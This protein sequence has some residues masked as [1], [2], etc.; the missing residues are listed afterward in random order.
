[1]SAEQHAPLLGESA[2]LSFR[3]LCLPLLDVGDSV[4][5]S[6]LEDGAGLVPNVCI[7]LRAA[8]ASCISLDA[9]AAAAVSG[10]GLRANCE[11]EKGSLQ[12]CF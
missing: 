3:R 1:M 9:I 10:G 11:T 6:P 8:C 7:G 2:F 4:T 12:R 5:E